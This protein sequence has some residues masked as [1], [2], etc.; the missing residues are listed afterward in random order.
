MTPREKVSLIEKTHSA[1]SIARQTQL[2]GIARSSIYYTPRP[3]AGDMS[4]M[5][6]LDALYTR[7]PFYGSRRMQW[8]LADEYGIIIGREHVQRVMRIMGIAALSPKQ[9]TSAPAPGHHI[10]P[11]LLRNLAIVH[12][13]QVW[14]T[15][16]TYVRLTHGFCYLTAM[17]DWFSRYVLSWE[18]SA[19]MEMDFCV[20]A[21]RSALTRAT[22]D[23]HNSDQGSQYTTPAYTEILKNSGVQISMDGRGRCMDNIF[24]ERLWRSVKYEEVY[25]KEYRTLDEARDGLYAYFPFYNT[26]RRHQALGNKTPATVYFTGRN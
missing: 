11:Y 16:I 21:L 17:M 2:L 1:I 7:W 5:H 4:I 10:Y 26:K 12:A 9:R 19:T 13:N 6:A 20:T 18:V 15:D 24:T 25:L 14:G 22:P 23:I 8:A 3:R